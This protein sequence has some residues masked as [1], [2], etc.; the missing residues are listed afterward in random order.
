M[1]AEEMGYEIHDKEILAIMRGLAEWSPL[2][3]SLQ[4]TPFLEITDHR[5]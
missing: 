2:L 3:I 4:Y 1:T 5:A